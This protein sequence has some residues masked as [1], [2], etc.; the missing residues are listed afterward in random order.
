MGAY[1]QLAL[2]AGNKFNLYFI[3]KIARPYWRHSHSEREGDRR[4]A[5][6]RHH[7]ADHAQG[8]LGGEGAEKQKQI[9]TK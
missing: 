4:Q 7:E 9:A 6:L 8:G 2:R 3:L 1:L 5:C